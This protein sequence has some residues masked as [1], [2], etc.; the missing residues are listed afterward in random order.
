MEGKYVRLFAIVASVAAAVLVLIVVVGRPGNRFGA[1]SRAPE[2]VPR[3][4]SAAATGARP[5][6]PRSAATAVSRIRASGGPAARIIAASANDASSGSAQAACKIGQ[7]L[8]R[9]ASIE[10]TL[11]LADAL[12]VVPAS[13]TTVDGKSLSESLLDQAA[14]GADHCAGIEAAT[15]DHAFAFQRAAASNG[16]LKH[17]RWLVT[18]PA[19]K[20]DRFVSDLD[21]WS[22]YR[23]E[24]KRYVQQALRERTVDDLPV[25]IAIFAPDVYRGPRPPYRVDDPATFAALVSVATRSG[26]EVPGDLRRLASELDLHAEEHGRTSNRTP[27]VGPSEAWN[28]THAAH[29]LP[30]LIQRQQADSFCD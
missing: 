8:M 7:Q 1:Q 17:L 24:A 23:N 25:L 6:L 2:P 14:L 15:T 10:P 12:A 16:G 29:S 3:V 30:G 26:I 4:M 27:L 19:L 9:C 13:S 20:Q 18:S 22:E 21:A 11:A 5:G 28:R